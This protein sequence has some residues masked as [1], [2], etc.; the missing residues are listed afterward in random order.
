MTKLTT[1]FTLEELASYEFARARGIELPD[2]VPEVIINELQNTANLLQLVRDAAYIYFGQE[3]KLH[4]TNAWRWKALND[5]VGSRDS[6]AH[7]WGGAADIVPRGCTI[8]ELFNFI[9]DSKDLM[10][11]IDQL[12]GERGCVHIGRAKIGKKPRHEVRGET[13]I[14]VNGRVERHYPLMRI[15][16]V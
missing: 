15:A 1:N 8:E 7:L 3:I 14:R 16:D 6:S 9:S 2:S 12:I 11:K 5:H 13:W 10:V 4:V